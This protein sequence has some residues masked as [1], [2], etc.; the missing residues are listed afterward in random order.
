MLPSCESKLINATAADFFSGDWF[1]VDEA[2]LKTPAF[3]EKHPQMKRKDAKYRTPML[4][5]AA[6]ITKPTA[7]TAIGFETCQPRSPR[8][9]LE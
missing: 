1:S 8:R 2:Q 4:R 5:V 9:S 3:A 7:A 6:E